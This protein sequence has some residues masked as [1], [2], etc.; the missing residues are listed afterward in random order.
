M[1]MDIHRYTHLHLNNGNPPGAAYSQRST[2]LHTLMI[3][4]VDQSPGTAAAQRRLGLGVSTWKP[5]ENDGTYNIVIY[6]YVYVYVYIYLYIYVYMY[7]YIC[8]YIYMCVCV[9]VY[10]IHV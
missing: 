3:C 6:I 5:L 2:Y 1:D 10:I 8:I 9:C 4:G 7:M